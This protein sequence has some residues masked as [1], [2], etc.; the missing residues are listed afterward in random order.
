MDQPTK[1]GAFNR[2]NWDRL[3]PAP[4]EALVDSNASPV[5]V[6]FPAVTGSEL[7]G[8]SQLGIAG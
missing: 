1:A 7:I 8:V 4:D 6:W 2:L 5:L 3:H